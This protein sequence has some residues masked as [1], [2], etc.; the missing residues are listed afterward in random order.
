MN[1][2]VFLVLGSPLKVEL[3]PM[4][5]DLTPTEGAVS[6][7]TIRAD[8]LEPFQVERELKHM[9]SLIQP[10]RLTGIPPDADLNTDKMEVLV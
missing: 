4:G 8:G 3:L 6:I 10:G 2:D 5:E 1:Y 7:G 9:I